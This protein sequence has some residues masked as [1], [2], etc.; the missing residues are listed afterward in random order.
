[1]SR[2]HGDGAARDPRPNAVGAA[3]QDDRHARTQ[4]E[5]GAIGVGQ[6]AELL[7]QHVPG[8]EIRHEKNVRIAGDRRTEFPSISAACLADRV[9][10]GQWAVEKTAGDL[11]SFGHLA[12]AAASIV[13]GIFEFTVSTAARMAT[14]GFSRPKRHGQI[15]GVLADVDLVLE[16]RV[17]C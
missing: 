15:D 5:T 1:M 9:V 7:G 10:E 17:R 4:Y 12:E 8:F 6:E 2:Q 14:L 16:G 3:C 11:P 13:A